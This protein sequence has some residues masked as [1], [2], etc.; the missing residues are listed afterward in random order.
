MLRDI[1]DVYTAGWLGA[2]V[3]CDACSAGLGGRRRD[4]PRARE[5]EGERE[6]ERERE[7]EQDCSRRDRDRDSWRERGRDGGTGASLRRA[8]LEPNRQSGPGGRP[9]CLD[10]AGGGGQVGMS[11]LHWETV[12]GLCCCHDEEGRGHLVVI[13]AQM[14]GAGL[15]PQPE[16]CT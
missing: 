5:R 8:P 10:G 2:A 7:R 11:P 13:P 15:Q 12:S 4:S 1:F 3:D 16:P 14:E 6:R 9:S